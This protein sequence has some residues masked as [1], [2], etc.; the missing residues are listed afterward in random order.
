MQHILL[1]IRVYN[2]KCIQMT[3]TITTNSGSA[4]DQVRIATV[5]VK[6]LA[7]IVQRRAYICS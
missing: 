3:I 1:D 5:Y 2:I 4:L 6:Q 7:T